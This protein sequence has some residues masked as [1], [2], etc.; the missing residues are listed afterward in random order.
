MTLLITTLVIMVRT[1]DVTHNG[2]REL[3]RES[4]FFILVKFTAIYLIEVSSE[5]FN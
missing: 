2:I 3:N 1:G 5:I 4:Y